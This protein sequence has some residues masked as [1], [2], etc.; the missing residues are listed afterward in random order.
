MQIALIKSAIYACLKAGCRQN[1][2]EKTD[3][4]TILRHHLRENKGF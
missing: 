2:R 1:Y 4:V 3:S